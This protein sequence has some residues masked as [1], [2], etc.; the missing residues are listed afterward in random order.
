[1]PN[2]EQKIRGL[3]A[4][5]ARATGAGDLNQLLTLMSDDVVFLTPGQQPM[6]RDAFAVVFQAAIQHVHIAAVSDV[7]EIKVAGDFAYCW[8]YLTVTVTPLKGGSHTRRSGYTLTIL[9]KKSDGSWVIA[10]D[11]NLLTAEPPA[12]A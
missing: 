2:D 10:R 3:I 1:M 5:W 6:R 4:T 12:A 9:R 8:N 11:A 7:Q